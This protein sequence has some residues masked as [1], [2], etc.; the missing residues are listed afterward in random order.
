RLRGIDLIE[1]KVLCEYI[2]ANPANPN[3]REYTPEKQTARATAPVFTEDAKLKV[4]KAAKNVTVRFDAAQSTDSEPVFLY[5]VKVLN[6]DGEVVKSDWVLPK[7]YS[8]TVEKHERLKLGKFEKG[9]YTVSVTAKTAWGAE[10]E[11][12]T[13][14]FTVK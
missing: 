1:Q 9:E 6:A 5:M 10:S 12:M 8:A 2:L 11:A 3:N 14:N 13:A 7:Y 4:F